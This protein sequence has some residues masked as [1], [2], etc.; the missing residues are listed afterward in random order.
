MTNEMSDYRIVT[1]KNNDYAVY[2]IF[3]ENTVFVIDN[4]NINLIKKVSYNK[5]PG[6]IINNSKFL[7]SEIMNHFFDNVLYVDHIN[8]IKLDNRRANLRLVTQS[9]QNKNQSKK[10]RNV[11]LPDK[12][13]INPQKIPTFIWYIKQNGLHGDRWAIQ[14][15]NKFEWKTTSSKK[16]S[17]KCKFELAKKELRNLKITRPELFIGHCM[18]GE[19]FEHA[20]VLRNEYNQIIQLA[21]Y[22]PLNTEN[23]E[24][25]LAEDIVNMSPE[26]IEFL[27]QSSNNPE[28]GFQIP[29]YCYYVSKTS[30]RSDGFCCDRKHPGHTK[31]WK[32]TRSSKISIEEKY[33][34]LIEYVKNLE[35]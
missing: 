28:N 3:K 31:D 1:Y 10:T 30:N 19:L 9:D 5:S 14:I 12:C 23:H 6:Y 7:H 33:N 18:N 29:K 27:R 26:E 15:K 17:T 21:G 32:S 8:R 34:Q 24:D 16:L 35:M 22:E 2:E 13:N 20:K 4:C 11:V 25:L